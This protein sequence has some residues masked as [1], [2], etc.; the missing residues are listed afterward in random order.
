[1]TAQRTEVHLIGWPVEHSLS[2]AMHT[3]AF[4]AL[5]LDWRYT[6]RPVAP[7]QVEPAIAALRVAGCRGANVTVPHKSAVLAHL[8]ALSDEAQAIGAVNTI[9]RHGSRL[10][11]H[12]TDAAGFLAALHA[13]GFDPARRRALLLGAGGG[14][15]AVAY[16]LARSGCAVTLYNRSPER[17]AHLARDLLPAALGAPV[18]A[19]PPGIRL[20]ALDPAAF[21]LL[22]NAT[23]VGMWPHIQ[24]SPWPESLPIPAHWLVCDLVY[25]PRATRL[26]WQARRSGARALGGLEML[27]HQGARALELWTGRPPPLEVMRAAAQDALEDAAPKRKEAS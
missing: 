4:R 21:D 27:V 2:P 10:S 12:N 19:L 5:G 17:A 23:P 9:V 20:A 22:V 11:G 25:R 14:A 8:D 6:L 18:A 16:A 24:A 7:G 3:A 1:M 15:R 13:A 26:L